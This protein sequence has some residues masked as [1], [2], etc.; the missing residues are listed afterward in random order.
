MTF[1]SGY[2]PWK[3]PRQSAKD[4][5]GA[6]KNLSVVNGYSFSVVMPA[7]AGIQRPLL[8]PNLW[9]ALDSRFTA[10]SP[11]PP[12]YGPA[13]LFAR[14]PGARSRGNDESRDVWLKEVPLVSEIPDAFFASFA[15]FASFAD[16]SLLLLASP[17]S[18]V[19]SHRF[20]GFAP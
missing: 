12:P 7:K 6:K 8:S 15:S 20:R 16:Q 14:A 13:S 2:A 11:S 5:K 9:K 4:A 17:K 3:K 19:P 1:L 10:G 18:R